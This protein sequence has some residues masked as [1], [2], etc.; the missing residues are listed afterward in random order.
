MI[1][2]S[3]SPPK[4]YASSFMLCVFFFMFLFWLFSVLLYLLFINFFILKNQK[5]TKIVCD[6][7]IGTCVPWMAF[8]TK[9]LNFVSLVT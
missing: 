9:F 6:V 3:H 2:F 7:Y 1:S 5:N 4:A 8:E